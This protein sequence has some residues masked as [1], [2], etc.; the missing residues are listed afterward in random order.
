MQSCDI[1]LTF[2]NVVGLKETTGW[3]E[4][5]VQGCAK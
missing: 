3:T 1:L 5:R 2:G 4:K